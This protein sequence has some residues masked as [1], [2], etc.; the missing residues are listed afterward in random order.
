M[1]PVASSPNSSRRQNVVRSGRRRLRSAA[2]RD[3]PIPPRGHWR[4]GGGTPCCRMTQ[5][6]RFVLHQDR[7]D[8]A[9]GQTCNAT[10]VRAYVM[11]SGVCVTVPA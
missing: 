4:G 3:L 1:K 5:K 8:I 7:K 10:R 2:L 6:R 9:A 11:L